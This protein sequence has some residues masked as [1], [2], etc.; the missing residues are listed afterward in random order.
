MTWVWVDPAVVELIHEEQLA[1]HGGAAGLRDAGLLASALARAQ[2]LA[3]Y[4]EPDSADLA[5]AYGFGLA[6]NHPF[7]DGNKRTAAV[8]TRLFPLLN[9]QDLV[10]TEAEVVVTF[11]ALAGGELTEP[12]LATWVRGHLAAAR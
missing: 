1:E 5:A 10:V 2:N 9:G 12:E 3:A 6:K 11:L 7:I 4:G 8:L